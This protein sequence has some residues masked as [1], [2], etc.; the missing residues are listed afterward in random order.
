MINSLISVI[1][2]CFNCKN[3]IM[4]LLLSLESQK[5][6]EFEVIIVD[7]GSTDNTS[8]VVSEYSLTS[9]LKIKYIIQENQGVSVAR[10]TGI[11]VA[12]GQ[13]YSFI[14]SDDV[15]NPLFLESLYNSIVNSDSDFSFTGFSTDLNCITKKNQIYTF[16]INTSISIMREIL[17]ENLKVG[18]WCFLFKSE[19]VNNNSIRFDKSTRYGEDREFIWKFLSCS[20]TG[21]HIKEALYGYRVNEFSAM[22]ISTWKKTD[23]LNAIKRTAVFINQNKPDIYKEYKMYAFSRALLSIYIDFYLSK[24]IEMISKLKSEYNLKSE[25]KKLKKFPNLKIKIIANIFLI[26]ENL[27]RLMLQILHRKQISS[28]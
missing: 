4:D 5:Y 10:N 7:D 13:F 21:V 1:I 26:N 16:S 22:S 2:P 19:I 14:D 8:Q 15:V 27:F 25:I 23:T 17:Y 6:K 20:K 24:N 11:S 28:R 18:I 12:S 3:Y 9:E